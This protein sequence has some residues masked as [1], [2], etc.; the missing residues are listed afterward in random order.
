MDVSARLVLDFGQRE[1]RLAESESQ[2]RAD[3]EEEEVVF[4]QFARALVGW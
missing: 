4:D 2:F 3:L 1:D